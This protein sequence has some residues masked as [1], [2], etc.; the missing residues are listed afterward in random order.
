MEAIKTAPIEIII[1]GIVML[2]IVISWSIVMVILA[3]K[4]FKHER[5]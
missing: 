5:I 1:T 3:S 4:I 2:T